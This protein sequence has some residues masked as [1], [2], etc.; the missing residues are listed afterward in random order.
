MSVYDR[1][2]KKSWDHYN[3]FMYQSLLQSAKNSMNALKKRI[4]SRGGH[5][6]LHSSRPFFEVDVQLMPPFVSL[7]PSLDAIQEY[8]NKSAQAILSCYKTVVDWGYS[9]LSSHEQK[10]HTFFERITK[11][12]EL[13]RVA[14]LL[15]GCI[16]GIKNTVADY[17][18][19]F[20]STTSFGNLTKI[21][22][23][24]YLLRSLKVLKI[25][26]DSFITMALLMPSQS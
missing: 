24:V 9:K 20:L 10:S 3:H 18:N 2:I 15:T 5:Q 19:L 23:T 6:I 11:D 1:D 16:Q 26:K 25:M 4:G 21:P 14:L 17:L 22:K 13:V 7:S 12:I 8:T